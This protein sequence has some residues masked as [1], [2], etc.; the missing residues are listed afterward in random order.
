VPAVQGGTIT[1][2]PD[3]LQ[4]DI[5][6][7]PLDLPGAVKVAVGLAPTLNSPRHVTWGSCQITAPVTVQL[8]TDRLPAVTTI[9]VEGQILDGTIR[10]ITTGRRIRLVGVYADA[11]GLDIDTRRLEIGGAGGVGMVYGDVLPDGG[12]RWFDLPVG[13]V[14][15][16]TLGALADADVS[17]SWQT[18]IVGNS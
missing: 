14:Y 3:G 4:Y 17:L 2:I 5:T 15:W 9:P 12:L 10:N 16:E 11:A 18:G 1:A 8:D 6:I 13:P 7:P